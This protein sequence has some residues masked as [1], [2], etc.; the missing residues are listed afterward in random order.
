MLCFQ[1]ALESVVQRASPSRSRFAVPRARF[2]PPLAKETRSVPSPPAPYAEPC[3]HH[4]AVVVHQPLAN[5]IRRDPQTRGTSTMAKNP[6]SGAMTFTPCKRFDAPAR[7]VAYIPARIAATQ[8]CGPVKRLRRRVLN[9]RRRARGSIA[10]A[11]ETSPEST[12]PGPRNIR[13][14]IRSSNMSSKDCSPARSGRAIRGDFQRRNV[15]RLAISDRLVNFVADQKQISPLAKRRDR[16]ELIAP[17]NGP[18]RIPGRIQDHRLRRRRPRAL[19]RFFGDDKSP[20]ANLRS[21]RS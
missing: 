12:A 4:H 17:Q 7:G 9:E 19:Q 16:F 1:F 18:H 21:Q 15:H 11:P 6:P 5:F 20:F 2:S 10:P 13:R 14:A 3:D 8:S